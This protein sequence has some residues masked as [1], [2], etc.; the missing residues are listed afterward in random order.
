MESGKGYLLLVHTLWLGQNFKHREIWHK[1]KYKLWQRHTQHHRLSFGQS[2]CLYHLDQ[3]LPTFPLPSQIPSHLKLN[4][5]ITTLI[6]TWEICIWTLNMKNLNSNHIAMGI[7]TTIL[8]NKVFHF[9]IIGHGQDI[10]NIH[11]PK[12]IFRNI[13]RHLSKGCV[14]IESYFQRGCRGPVAVNIFRNFKNFDLISP[15]LHNSMVESCMLRWL[16]DSCCYVVA[17]HERALKFRYKSNLI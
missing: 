15:S 3:T 16:H 7:T 12:R 11:K 17:L 5:R 8:T 6:Y 4:D 14:L 2:T 10:R 1:I 13:S 9:H